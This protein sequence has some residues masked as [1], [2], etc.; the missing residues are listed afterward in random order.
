MPN[1]ARSAT[2]CE[3]PTL[4]DNYESFQSVVYLKSALVLLMLD[5]LLGQEELFKRLRL[6]LEKFK[7]KSVTS[8]MLINE[9][10]KKEDWLLKFFNGWLFSRKIPEITCQVKLL[11]TTAELR[12]SQKDTDFVFPL[13]VRMETE[14]GKK[15]QQVIV[16]QKNQVFT[17]SETAAIKSLKVD[18]G[19][20]LV[21]IKD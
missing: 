20:A 10:S 13:R 2:A 7:Y 18:V 11:G 12:V 6:C 21:V 4:K 5:D 15:N 19:G 8:A 16:R 17:F 3:S 1:A 14:Q 9:I